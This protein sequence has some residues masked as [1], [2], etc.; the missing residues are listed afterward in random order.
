MESKFQE[1]LFVKIKLNQNDKLLVGII[2]RSPSVK[3][4]EYNNEL[5]TLLTEAIKKGFSHIL[6]MGD[7]NYPEINWE[8]W[9]T[10]SDNTENIENKFI[11]TVQDNFLFQHVSKPT[12]WRGTDTPHILD[13]IMT[14]EE[15]MIS[16]LEHTSPLGKSDH[17]CLTF[18]FNCYVNIKESSKI[19][20]LYE[21][22][23]YQD[24]KYDLDQYD[25]VETLKESEDID[26]NWDKF[27]A[28]LRE[29]ENKY[30][31][32]RTRKQIGRSKNNFPVDKNTREK[33]RR[34]NILSKK[35]VRSK[36]PE[37]RLEYNKVRNQVK[38]MVNK[39]KKKYEK[40]LSQKAKENP[41]AIW[42]Y[43]K[44][45]SKTREGIG[46]LHVDPEDIKSIKTEDNKEKANILSEYF[47]SVFTKEPEGD[48]P[49]PNDIMVKQDMPA[50]TVTENMVLKFLQTLKT[51]K[52]PG[53]DSLHPRL[54][55][56]LSESIVN[57]L[58]T[59]FNQSLNNRKVPKQWK[60]ALISAIFKK[61]NKSQAKN[62]RP[63][64]LTSI[65][66]KIME[67]IIR[68]HIIEHMKV[69]GLFQRSNID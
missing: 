22:G 45:K 24:F 16:N 14:N 66:C 30:I 57:P 34:K 67:K 42:S 11:D 29:M 55:K 65:V 3:T 56:E 58:C 20:R 25:W 43:I 31:P 26:T 51:D 52:S 17:C 62:Y 33:I 5:C 18:D 1:N 2:Y 35:A 19:V 53:P 32:T 50:I 27:L 41:K 49:V 59:I 60:N 36:D 37:V 6:I 4:F 46:D 21:K 47:S 23:N 61:G 44:S 28:I 54:L 64:S 15:P 13:L 8:S 48:V 9:N 68:E 10:K 39:L 38:N 40:G 7:F 69:N 12:R 63:V